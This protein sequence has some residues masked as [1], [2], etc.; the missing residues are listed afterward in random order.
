MSIIALTIFQLCFI[1]DDINLQE[2]VPVG[3]NEDTVIE[4]AT[5]GDTS[6]PLSVNND[7]N[8]GNGVVIFGGHDPKN[9][10]RFVEMGRFI[11]TSRSY[12]TSFGGAALYI[13]K[14]IDE[15]TWSTYAGGMEACTCHTREPNP[16][17]SVC[18]E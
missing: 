12:T 13:R 10:N 9:G 17:P 14:G 15:I 1:N 18:G 16:D 7:N 2:C 5:L 8:P 6:T 3:F 4:C 11:F